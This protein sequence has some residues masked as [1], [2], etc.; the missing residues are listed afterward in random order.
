[1]LEREPEFVQTFGGSDNNCFA[2]HGIPGL[3]L[4][5][6]MQNVHT[7]DEFIRIADIR[8]SVML[9]LCLAIQE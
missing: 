2:E 7:V 6:G 4:S 1:M 3:V 5:C 8:D 9:I